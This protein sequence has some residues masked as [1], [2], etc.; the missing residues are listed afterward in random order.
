MVR[1]VPA[2]P[3]PVWPL[4]IRRR[5]AKFPR[6]DPSGTGA[7]SGRCPDGGQRVADHMM[8]GDPCQSSE[9]QGPTVLVIE[10]EILVRFDVAEVLRGAG[11]R[12]IEAS[13]A[14]EAME[15]L[16]AGKSVDFV[17]TD[18]EMPGTMNGLEFCTAVERR[19]PRLKFLV[20]SGRA[21]AEEA[22]SIRLFVPKP[23][24]P[25][26]V[27]AHIRAALADQPPE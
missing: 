16:E 27:V 18:I 19:F 23:Y 13:N 15:H 2:G 7:A 24:D 1:H 6:R 20:T 9:A 17:F 25:A 8:N 22:A 14:D 12:V 5:C 10:D 26:D 3:D 11:M 4:S 21:S